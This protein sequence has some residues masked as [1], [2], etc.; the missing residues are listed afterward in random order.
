MLH[1]DNKC[2]SRRSPWWSR[3]LHRLRL[4]KSILQ[5]LLSGFNT[6]GNF[7]A[8][9]QKLLHDHELQAK[10]LPA[11]KPDCR[12]ALTAVS[13]SIR[14]LETNSEHQRRDQQV[15]AAEIYDATGQK[16]KAKLVKE[17]RQAEAM[18]ETFRLFTNIHSKN[19]TSSLTQ[20]EIPHHWPHIQRLTPKQP[21]LRG[22]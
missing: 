17:I 16:D 9:L 12:R 1:G 15:A 6:N 14:E 7:D 22:K 4:W 2:R 3:K 5:C 11:N 10:T 18:S 20:I 13:A 21:I 8:T 19:T